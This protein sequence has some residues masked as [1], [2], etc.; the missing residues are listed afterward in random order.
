M[1]RSCNH[2]FHQRTLKS[3]RLTATRRKA[4]RCLAVKLRSSVSNSF[5]SYGTTKTHRTHRN[6][7]RKNAASQF[8]RQM[9]ASAFRLNN[10]R[11]SVVHR[12]QIFE[13]FSVSAVLH[14]ENGRKFSIQ[15]ISKPWAI[16]KSVK[17][18]HGKPHHNE[19]E[20]S[21]EKTIRTY[22]KR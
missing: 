3:N 18:A 13:T 8:S 21:I 20:Y 17:I 15:I 5:Y 22:R 12:F 1:S 7:Q 19:T 16:W 10:W 11:S 6:S 14:S 9:N 4:W 2:F